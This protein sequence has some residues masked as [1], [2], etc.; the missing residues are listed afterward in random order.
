MTK[1]AYNFKKRNLLNY[2]EMGM[3]DFNKL[4]LL[5]G[6]YPFNT[7]FFSFDLICIKNDDS[8]V[9]NFFW[10]GHH[11]TNSLDLWGEIT[12]D[13]GLYID[14]GAHTGLYTIVGLLSNPENVVISIEPSFLNMGRLISNLRLNG[15]FKNN[16]RF[17]GA[18]SKV[19][20]QGFF[21]VHQDFSLMS[22]GGLLSDKGERVDIIKLDDIQINGQNKIIKGLKIDTEGEDYNVL[23]GAE[24]LIKAFK[25]QI[26]IE[27][28]NENKEKI[29]HFLKLFNYKF[30]LLED[31]KTPIDLNELD[32][33][34]V[35]N[36]YAK[37]DDIN[38]SNFK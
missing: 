30:Y 20:G 34:N 36:I 23:L 19:S 3:I 1:E 29:E 27:V 21:K 14:I 32:I 2:D 35:E 11:D 10:K 25:P 22:K 6:V 8:S 33:S 26:I 38:N 16:S 24:N 15:L 37:P 4:P 13:K 18:A 12:K 28:R 31:T 5:S 9:V 17:L 7:K